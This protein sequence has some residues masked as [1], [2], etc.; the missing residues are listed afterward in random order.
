[1]L[2]SS[3]AM[4]SQ[5]IAG[6]EE[7][8]SKLPPVLQH[9]LL[10]YSLASVGALAFI[11]A[12]ATGSARRPWQEAS[13]SFRWLSLEGNQATRYSALGT[14]DPTTLGDEDEE[15]PSFMDRRLS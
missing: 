3:D 12:A 15:R 5:A 9:K 8:G 7:V 11:Y 10:L 1:M 13:R 14:E 2:V 4:A 6:L